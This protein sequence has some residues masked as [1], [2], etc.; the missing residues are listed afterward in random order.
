[1]LERTNYY[2]RLLVRGR[3][4]FPTVSFFKQNFKRT[5][6][7]LHLIFS[8]LPKK[9]NRLKVAQYFE[10]LVGIKK[11]SKSAYPCGNTMKGT[12]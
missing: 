5:K 8:Y 9:F 4:F 11:E 1:M 10:K 2:F 6:N 12:K 7:P 3:V